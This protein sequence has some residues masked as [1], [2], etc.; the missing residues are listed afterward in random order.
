MS[1]TATTVL[2]FVF[3]LVS[4]T[5]FLEV[6]RPFDVLPTHFAQGGRF[7][8]VHDGNDP[9]MEQCVICGFQSA[10]YAA[11]VTHSLDVHGNSPAAI[12]HDAMQQRRKK[13]KRKAGDASGG[14]APLNV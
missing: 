11:L 6:P 10:A 8:L 12:E 7:L 5:C 3:S 2:F 9:D 13:R 4:D 14:A 1:V